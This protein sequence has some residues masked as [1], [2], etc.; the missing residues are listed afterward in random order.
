MDTC[1]LTENNTPLVLAGG[2]TAPV[3]VYYTDISTLVMTNCGQLGTNC[4]FKITNTSTGTIYTFRYNTYE[5]QGSI[6]AILSYVSWQDNIIAPAGQY[7][8]TAY[9]SEK[10]RAYNKTMATIGDSITWSMFGKYLRC[11]LTNKGINCDFVGTKTDACGFAHEGEGGNTTVD[12]YNRV[13]AIPQADTYFILLGTNDVLI[14]YTPLQTVGDLMVIARKLLTKYPNSK[15]Y[16][17]TLLP[18]YSTYLQRNL[19]I[20]TILKSCNW[21]NGI[22]I[23]DLGGYFYSQSNWQSLLQPDVLHPNLAGY[24]VITDYLVSH[25]Q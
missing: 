18:R 2:P 20:N 11:Q 5:V 16:I 17:S 7:T 6:Y 9:Y 4:L 14:N 12:V 15:V 24:N 10:P 13:D 1:I 22:E 23:V 19:D 21:G 3:T 8:F 25:I